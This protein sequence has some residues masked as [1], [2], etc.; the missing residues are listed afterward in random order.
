MN[1]SD[2]DLEN[3]L[4]AACPPVAPPAPMRK[5]VLA[6]ASAK[7]AAGRALLRFLL[8]YAA[9]VLTMV[10]VERWF[11]ARPEASSAAP[12]ASVRLESIADRAPPARVD[13]SPPAAEPE[14]PNPLPVPRI[15]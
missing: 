1:L 13:A 3:L 2:R 7:R 4:R 10:A 6:A 11:L 12:V 9:G 8:P 14:S 15:S 5:R